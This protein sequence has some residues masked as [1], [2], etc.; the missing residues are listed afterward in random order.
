MSF[1]DSHRD[2]QLKGPG[3]SGQFVVPGFGSTLCGLQSSAMVHPACNESLDTLIK[4]MAIY[5][6][7][8]VQV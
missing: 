4:S 3:V 8:S 2:F 1:V 6:H 5:S 7:R